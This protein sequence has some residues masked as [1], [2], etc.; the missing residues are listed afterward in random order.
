MLTQKPDQ[1]RQF[2]KLRAALVL[3]FLGLAAEACGEPVEQHK[4]G[5]EKQC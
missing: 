1:F 4:G 5:H 2:D 3:A